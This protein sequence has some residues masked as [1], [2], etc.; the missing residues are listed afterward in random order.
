MKKLSVFLI[1][2]SLG[3]MIS[4]NTNNVEAGN[5]R[6]VKSEGKTHVGANIY[7]KIVDK[8]TGCKFL[9]VEAQMDSNVAIT[10]ILDWDGKPICR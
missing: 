8:E 10:Q 2:L 9:V 6:V 3:I 5:K 4:M 7:T 1:V